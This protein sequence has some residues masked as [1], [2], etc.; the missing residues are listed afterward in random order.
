MTDR[1]N[2]IFEQMIALNK[3][4]KA[5]TQVHLLPLGKILGRDGREFF[6]KDV[7]Q[8]IKNSISRFN[9][10]ANSSLLDLVIDYE[11]QTDYAEI[12][13]QPAPAGGWIK[14]LFAKED[15]L[16]GDVEWTPKA[17]KMI[18]EFEYRYL[19]PVFTHDKQ[20]N[21]IALLHAGLTNSPN[22]ELKSFN[23]SL[24]TITE[25][26]NKLN[27]LAQLIALLGL[28]E[29]A[30]EADAIEAVK[31]LQTSASAEASLNK[32]AATLGVSNKEDEIIQAINSNKVDPA[33]YVGMTEYV[34]LN[35]KC[36]ELQEKLSTQEAETA[37]NKA[38][39]EGRLMPAL[40]DN[41]LAIHKAQGQAALEDFISKFTATA[42]NKVEA[43]A[44]TPATTVKL[45]SEEVALCKMMGLGQEE[46]LAQKKKEAE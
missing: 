45:Q 17:G 32:V 14:R 4:G 40:K 9:P 23:K 43:S 34:S 7:N 44:S 35:K 6:L 3:E 24:I 1:K 20:G 33:K 27:L 11:H 25:E 5:P 15:G 41:A 8:V 30:T 28:A 18:E 38:V 2:N 46:Y 13:G 19:S 39:E 12:N 36:N 16:W 29:G 10:T 37:I 22:L 42:L 21:V 31:K 26:D